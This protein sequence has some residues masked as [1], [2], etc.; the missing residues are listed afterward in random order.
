MPSAMTR[1]E[2]HRP[3]QVVVGVQAL[4]DVGGDDARVQVDDARGSKPV[5]ATGKA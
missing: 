2:L 4:E 5:S 3:R 1:A